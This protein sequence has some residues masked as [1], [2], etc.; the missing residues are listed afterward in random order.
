MSCEEQSEWERQ[1]FPVKLHRLLAILDNPTAASQEGL[2]VRQ[3]GGWNPDG[4]SFRIYN[5]EHF[6]VECLPSIFRQTKFKSYQRQLGIYGFQRIKSS[7][8]NNDNSPFEI[9]KTT[10]AS[11]KFREALVVVSKESEET[12]AGQAACFFNK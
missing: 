6:V 9:T 8:D 7:N 12:A 1:R 4:K 2:D 11:W 10:R 5:T 3:I